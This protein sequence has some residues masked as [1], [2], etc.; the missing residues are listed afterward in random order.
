MDHLPPQGGIVITKIER[1][2]LCARNPFNFVTL[3]FDAIK[4]CRAIV[5]YVIAATT[6]D[7]C[8]K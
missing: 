2:H 7:E 3:L 8:K 5:G 1:M 6:V 4:F